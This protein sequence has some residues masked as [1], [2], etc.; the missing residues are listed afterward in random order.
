MNSRQALIQ[1]FKQIVIE[2][3]NNPD[4]IHH[5]WFVEYHLNIVEQIAKELLEYYPQADKD[6]VNVLVWLHDYGKTIDFANQYAVT[7]I[8]GRRQLIKVGFDEA[9]V[10]RAIQYI[11]I[12]DKKMEVDLKQAPIEVQI[13]SSAD[14]CSH[15]VGPFLQLWWWENSKKNYKEL[16]KDNLYKINKDWMRKI[17]LPEAR[18]AFEARYNFLLEQSGGIPHKF[19]S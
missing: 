19:L 8:E 16:M 10:D 17:V 6:L 2:S 11:E 15:Y 1:S 18:A 12:I 5:P 7:P 3:S 9:F 13:V 14:G 4:F